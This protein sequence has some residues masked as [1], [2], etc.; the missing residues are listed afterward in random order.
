[1][2]QG[3]FAQGGVVVEQGVLV[4]GDDLDGHV[5]FQDADTRQ[6]GAFE[7][8]R[9]RAPDALLTRRSFTHPTAP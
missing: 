9:L 2:P 3:Q 1:M 5:V 7:E 6:E 4:A 8:N